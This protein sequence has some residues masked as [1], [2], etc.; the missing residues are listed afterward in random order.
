MAW[1]QLSAIAALNAAELAQARDTPLTG[2]PICGEPLDEARSVLHCRLGH[3]E[4]PSGTT[5]S[6]C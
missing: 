2:C 4:A 5:E 3:W 1:D 6:D